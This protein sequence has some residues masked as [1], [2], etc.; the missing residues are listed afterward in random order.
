MHESRSKWDRLDTQSHPCSDRIASTD[1]K[2]YFVTKLVLTQWYSLSQYTSKMAYT[3]TYIY[4][5]V[6]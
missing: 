5:V 3:Y 1:S 2:D 6:T 4:M